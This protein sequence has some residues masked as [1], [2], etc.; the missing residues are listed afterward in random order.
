[1]SSHVI[2]PVSPSFGII[3]SRDIDVIVSCSSLVVSVV[4]LSAFVV[5]CHDICDLKVAV[6]LP[7]LHSDNQESR[8]LE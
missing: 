5:L 4:P 6:V 8:Q 3:T 7:S 1:M 2:I